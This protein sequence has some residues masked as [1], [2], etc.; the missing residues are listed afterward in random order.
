MSQTEWALTSRK[1][2]THKGPMTTSKSHSPEVMDMRLSQCLH[3]P[4]ATTIHIIEST[5]PPQNKKHKKLTL[6]DEAEGLVG[7]VCLARSAAGAVRTD[8]EG[9][10]LRPAQVPCNGSLH[11]FTKQLQNDTIQLHDTH[12]TRSTHVQDKSWHTLIPYAC[13]RERLGRASPSKTCSDP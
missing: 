13:M 6:S 3:P 1:M 2:R 8:G 10:S 5:T 9:H 11:S 7:P 4:A 12:K